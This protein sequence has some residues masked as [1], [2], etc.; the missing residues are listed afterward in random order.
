MAAGFNRQGG[1]DSFLANWIGRKHFELVASDKKALFRTLPSI[2]RD[3]GNN[4]L[5]Q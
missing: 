1:A 2:V 4:L 3:T 5:V